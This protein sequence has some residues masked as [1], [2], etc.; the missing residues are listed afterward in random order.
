MK[1]EFARGMIISFSGSHTKMNEVVLWPWKMQRSACM[2]MC[3]RCLMDASVF[4]QVFNYCS[5]VASCASMVSREISSPQRCVHVH[6]VRV[7]GASCA[8]VRRYDR[9]ICADP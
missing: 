2:M 3:V 5:R 4:V 1:I 7:A 6:V 9:L 8:R